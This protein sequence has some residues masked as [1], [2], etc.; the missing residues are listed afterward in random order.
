MS[1]WLEAKRQVLEAAQAITESGGHVERIVAVLDRQQGAREN[2][3]A[4]G[5]VFEAL[6][7]SAD[8]GISRS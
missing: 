2:I 3:E 6:L 4:A 7:T 1:R 8:L 5:F